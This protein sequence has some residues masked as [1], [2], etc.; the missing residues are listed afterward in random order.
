[1]HESIARALYRGY[2]RRL[3]QRPERSLRPPAAVRTR[4]A[5]MRQSLLEIERQPHFVMIEAKR[6]GHGKQEV[7]MVMGVWRQPETWAEGWQGIAF[8]LN[9]RQCEVH[10][11]E[12]PV[13]LTHHLIERTLQRLNLEQ[14]V[15]AIQSLGP[16]IYTA[17]W[18]AAIDGGVDGNRLL[19]MPGGA[20]IAAPA[21]DDPDCWALVTFVDDDKLRPAQRLDIQA[22]ARRAQTHAEAF[23]QL[24][25]PIMPPPARQARRI[26]APVPRAWACA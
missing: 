14:P 11:V 4:G 15:A 9:A 1:M 18:N 6:H 8:L 23:A 13:R 16:A 19:G 21:Q 10:P 3:D 24:G 5:W 20:V 7:A 26:D 12:I 2:V 17:L 25:A 22:T